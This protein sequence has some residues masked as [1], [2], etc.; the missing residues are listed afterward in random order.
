[1]GF[2]LHYNGIPIIDFS[3]SDYEK[4]KKYIFNKNFNL[5]LW[6]KILRA[7]LK[8]S[9][10]DSMFKLFFQIIQF[11]CQFLDFKKL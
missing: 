10:P 11:S 9:M 6:L 2:I 1:M 3:L 5:I 8:V 7:L 4:I